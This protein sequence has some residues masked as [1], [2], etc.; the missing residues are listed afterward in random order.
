MVPIKVRVCWW[1]QADFLYQDCFVNPGL[2]VLK[3]CNK[4]KLDLGDRHVS[5]YGSW[6]SVDYLV[7]DGDRIEL[8]SPVRIDVKE[9]RRIRSRL[10]KGGN[11]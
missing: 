5:C 10:K 6:V 1:R 11:G 9:A 2:T 4:L 7:Q 8:H 3:L